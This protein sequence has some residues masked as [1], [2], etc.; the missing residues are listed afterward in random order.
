MGGC[1]L[2]KPK[3]RHR[4]KKAQHGDTSI[5]RATDLQ[6][7]VIRLHFKSIYSSQLLVIIGFEWLI[8]IK[9]SNL[10]TKFSCDFKLDQYNH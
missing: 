5:S 1:H 8:V 9:N 2:L 3:S 4:H 7:C 6:K 10:I